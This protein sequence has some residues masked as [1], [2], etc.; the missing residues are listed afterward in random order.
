MDFIEKR[1][2]LAFGKDSA[3]KDDKYLYGCIARIKRYPNY[4]NKGGFVYAEFEVDDPVYGHTIEVFSIQVKLSK[5][6]Y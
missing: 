5:E 6:R 2:I 3:W 1:K 4:P